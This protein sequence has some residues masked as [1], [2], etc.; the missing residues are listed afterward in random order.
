MSVSEYKYVK[1]STKQIEPPDELH[2]VIWRWS[3]KGW[4]SLEG[5]RWSFHSDGTTETFEAY[6]ARL[7]NNKEVV[8]EIMNKEEL[9]LELL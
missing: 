3:P 4:Y 2:K 5:N 6:I 7:N 1:V 9:F 8:F